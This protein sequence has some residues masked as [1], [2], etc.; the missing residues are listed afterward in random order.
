LA[1]GKYSFD[2]VFSSDLGRAYETARLA[3]PEHELTVDPRLREIHFGAFEG[4]NLEH[5][6]ATEH[7]EFRAWW[8]SP[9]ER[10]LVGGE[11][12]ADL[13]ARVEAWR[14]EQNGT[15][16]IAVFTHG[17]VI[18]DALWRE[19]SPPVDGAWSFIL[20]NASLTVISYGKRR[21]TILRVND[22]AHLETEN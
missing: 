22:C 6:E 9:Y 15:T 2:K 19:T 10:T 14:S 4:R 18:R 8:N 13:R 5:L 21:N 3:L 11:S 1:N 16:N 17:G 20:D 7:E 12:M